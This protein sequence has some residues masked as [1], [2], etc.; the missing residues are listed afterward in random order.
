MSEHSKLH[1]TTKLRQPHRYSH[2]LIKNESVNSQD[3]TKPISK[4]HNKKVIN[5]KNEPSALRL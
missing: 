3:K 4:L 5:K 2:N 1:A